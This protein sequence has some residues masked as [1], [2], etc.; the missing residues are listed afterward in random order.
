MLQLTQ[1]KLP[2]REAT[3]ENL[4]RKT[5]HTL[6]LEEEEITG[7]EIVKK[8]I[9]ARRKPDI[10]ATYTVRFSAAGEERIWKRNR[11]NTR[12]SRVEK[13]PSLW[14][15]IHP[16]PDGEKV[17]IVGAGP[18]GFFCAYYLSLCGLRPLLIERGAP[19]EE[20]VRDV[21]RFWQIGRASC[22][23]RVLLIV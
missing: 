18:A 20:R 13:E 23:E 10:F 12:L 8:S 17:V 3:R 2:Y 15:K 16:L 19:M 6:H 4:I 1:C 22:R 9:D 21:E 5:A 11:K 7:F 14:N